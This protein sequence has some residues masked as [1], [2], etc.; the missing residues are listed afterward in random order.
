MVLL[1]K[2]KKELNLH[3]HKI[4]LF[5]PAKKMKAYVCQKVNG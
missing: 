3:H 5:L 2:K 4:Q 1:K